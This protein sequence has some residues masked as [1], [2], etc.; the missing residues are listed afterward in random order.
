VGRFADLGAVHAILLVWFDSTRPVNLGVV[1]EVAS[2]KGEE[3]TAEAPTYLD[4]DGQQ[5]ERVRTSDHICAG[6]ADASEDRVG[7]SVAQRHARA[8]QGDPDDRAAIAD[9]RARPE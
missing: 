5:D 6:L 1:A 7:K 3:L 8:D 2:R 4:T 9:Q